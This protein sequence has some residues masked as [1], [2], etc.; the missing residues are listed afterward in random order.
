[1]REIAFSELNLSNGFGEQLCKVQEGG[2][3]E[4]RR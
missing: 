3:D 4:E 2:N 1:M